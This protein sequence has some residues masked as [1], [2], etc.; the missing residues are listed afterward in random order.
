M[1]AA[2]VPLGAGACKITP[3]PSDPV[4]PFKA[5]PG[6]VTLEVKSV[7][8]AVHFLTAEYDGN[9]ISGMPS[10]QITFTI[11]AGKK[12]LNVVY[13]FTDTVSGKGTLHEVCPANTFLGIVLAGVE[14]VGYVICGEA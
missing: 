7:I 11:V 12:N 1:S 8:G 13:V 3:A 9:P 6:P 10:N 4:C 2:I 14:V 5:V